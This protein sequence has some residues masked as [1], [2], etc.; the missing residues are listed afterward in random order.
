V[1]ILE[2][3]FL[4]GEMSSVDNQKEGVVFVEETAEKRA[5]VGFKK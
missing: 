3:T 5:C 1:S 2:D 4:V